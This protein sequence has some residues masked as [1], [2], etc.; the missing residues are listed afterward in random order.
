MS[1]GKRVSL[2]TNRRGWTV[3][4]LWEFWIIPGG[5][6]ESR[7]SCDAVEQAEYWRKRYGVSITDKR[8]DPII[9][10]DHG[11]NTRQV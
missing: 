5:V 2:H 10:R 9:E 4:T 6:F 11:G 3:A 7:R 1:I 8:N